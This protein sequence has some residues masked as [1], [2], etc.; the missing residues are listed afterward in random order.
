V[1]SQW[2]ALAVLRL[3]HARSVQPV[4]DDVLVVP[5]DRL[6]HLLRVVADM[7]LEPRSRG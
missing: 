4:E 6:T 2:R 7:P 3:V 1:E 5:I